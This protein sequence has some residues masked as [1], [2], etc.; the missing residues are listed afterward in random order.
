MLAV[1]EVARS[2]DDVLSIVNG[3]YELKWD[4]KTQLV[5]RRGWLQSADLMTS[6]DE[7]RLIC[8]DAGR[9][10]LAKLELYVPNQTAR[11]SVSPS[12]VQVVVPEADGSASEIEVGSVEAL[13]REIEEAATDSSD[14]D[15]FERAVRDAFLF[16]GFVADWLGGPGKTDVLVDAPLGRDESYRVTVDAKTTASGSLGDQQVDWATLVEHRRKHEADFTLLVAPNPSEGRLMS[17]A[18]EYQVA[19]MSAK[20]LAGLCRQHSRTPLSLTDYRLLFTRAGQVDTTE[21]DE[22][23]E[24]SMRLVALGG[25]ICSC[26]EANV[27][28][29]GRLQAHDLWLLLSNDEAGEVSTEDEIQELLNTLASPLVRAVDG[30]IGDGYVLASNLEVVRMRLGLLGEALTHS[31]SK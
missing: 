7:G 12:S 6:D 10:L 11:E 5:N 27:M 3:E 26:L 18:V 20:Q 13:A 21:L 16:L 24:D 31:V 28:K 14:S 25:A 30:T 23:A 1:T 8:T 19:V 4:T 15:R 9:E 17:R 29:F 22:L 2:T